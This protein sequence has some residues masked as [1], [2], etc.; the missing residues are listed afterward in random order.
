M[1]FMSWHSMD[2]STRDAR[3]RS[4]ARERGTTPR[5][6]AFASSSSSA[7]AGAMS[8]T[9]R[10]ASWMTR[11]TR[12][13]AW[14]TTT[15]RA[16]F[17]LALALV[18]GVVGILGVKSR[19]RAR[20]ARRLGRR[21]GARFRG[22]RERARRETRGTRVRGCRGDDG[23]RERER[24]ERKRD[25]G[26]V[27]GRGGECGDALGRTGR[28]VD[29]RAAGETETRGDGRARKDGPSVDAAAMVRSNGETVVSRA[30]ARGMSG[31]NVGNSTVV[32]TP[33]R[34]RRADGRRPC[35]KRTERCC[36][37]N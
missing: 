13:T 20:R 18:V 5:G 30:G 29:V 12:P 6:F 9:S 19:A 14:E 17:A 26:G 11:S 22:R 28:D 35:T 7:K 32:K 1:D 15:T 25:G 27:R 4:M 8:G 33:P 10:R 34:R 2:D 36:E 23:A 3:A 37:N 21:R 16:W 24:R 31:G